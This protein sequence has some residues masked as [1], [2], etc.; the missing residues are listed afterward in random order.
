[1]RFFGLIVLFCGVGLSSRAFSSDNLQ[2]NLNVSKYKLDNGLT[3]LLHED[4]TVPMIS[5]HTWYKVGSKN[6]KPGVTGAAHMLEHMMFKGGKKY[7]GSEYEKKLHE[8]GI[9]N[10]AFTTP[11]FTG[12]YEDLPSD[13]L[14]M[15]MDL[16]V[17]R[18]QSLAIKNDD[19]V[20]ERDVVAEERRWRVDN[21]PMGLLHEALMSTVFSVS[22]YRWPVIGYMNDIAAYTSEKLRYFYETFYVPNNAVLVIVGDFNPVE[23]KKMI[24]K[25][26]GRLRFKALP[27]QEFPKE[28]LQQEAKQFE[29]VKNIESLSVV[30]AYPS[31][32]IGEADAYVMDLIGNILGTGSSSRLHRTLVDQKQVATSAFAVN[33]TLRDEGV[34]A[35]GVNLK[36]GNDKKNQVTEDLLAE[37]T[38]L[39]KNKLPEKDLQKA[40]NQMLKEQIESLMTMDGKARALAVNEI[41]TGSYE[42]LFNDLK[43]YDAVTAEAVQSVAKKYLTLQRSSRIILTPPKK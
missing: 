41:Q 39:Q 43:K 38:R 20:S 9:E 27:E 35:L 8:N 4:H 14:E 17:D 32:K 23:I 24:N 10:N 6:E 2:I 18:M 13:K 16:E 5:Y 34:F 12:F 40:K 25:Y 36:P 15:I 33:Y 29:V 7:S 28:P 22:N 19:L 31:P 37:V 42:N 30:L 1:M 26:Y 21:N 3:V 11:D